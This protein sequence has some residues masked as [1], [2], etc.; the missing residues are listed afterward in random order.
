MA[1]PQIHAEAMRITDLD[2]NGVPLPGA[3]HLYVTHALTKVT[4][5]PQYTDGDAI[6]DKNA[7]GAYCINFEEDPNFDG[8]EVEIELCDPDP[9]AHAKLAGGTVL[10][11]VDPDVPGYAYPKMG[12]VTGH[13]VSV[14]LWAKRIDDDDLDEAFPY[15]WWTLP[16]LKKAKIG[17]KTF[18]KARLTNVFTGKAIENTNWFDGP[19]N[20][21]PAAS[22]RVVQW[23]PTTG[24]PAATSAPV[25]VA[26][27]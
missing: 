25:A 11:D 19:L 26:A 5:K 17:D 23:V 1:L 16:K 10:T 22:D 9:Y 3:G 6:R 21:W 20:D 8:L 4:L 18:E 24:F 2:R 7:N 14:E 12:V 13:G 27:S 15:A